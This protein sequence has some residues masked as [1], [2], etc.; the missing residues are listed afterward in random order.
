MVLKIPRPLTKVAGPKEIVRQFVPSWFAVTMGTG[1]LAVVIYDFPFP[2]SHQSDLGWA[3]WFFNVGLF[4]LFS[5]LFLSRWIFFFKD[6][7]PMFQHPVQSMFLGAIPMGLATIVNG[8]V[9]FGTPHW[10]NA[11]TVAAIALWFVDVGL[12]VLTG[13]LVPIFMVT[14]HDHTLEM[15]TAVWVLPVVPAE[16]A[17]ASG[18]LLLSVVQNQRMAQYI[19][20]ISM[21]LWG[22]SVPLA[23]SILVVFFLRLVLHKLPPSDLIISCLLPLGPIGTAALAA[24]ELGINA[25]RTFEVSGDGLAAYAFRSLAEA[26]P[27]IGILVASVLWGYGAWWLVVAIFAIGRTIKK[28]LPFNLGWWGLIFP[29]GVFTAATVDLYKLTGFY[30]FRIPAAVF[31]CVLFVLWWIVMI[32]TFMRAY[33]GELFYAPCLGPRQVCT[34]NELEI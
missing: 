20:F 23:F 18:G 21:L 26:S 24:A 32:H 14:S 33:S 6:A 27:A 17:A 1:I 5:V 11:A 28:Q 25:R 13:L 12:S 19:A 9:L 3:Y 16:V 34:Q 4:S 7:V 2:F 15:M 22:F 10:G 29:L 31:I 8:L 30:L